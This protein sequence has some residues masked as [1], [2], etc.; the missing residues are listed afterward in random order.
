MRRHLTPEES[1]KI[2]I[3]KSQGA[4]L[5]Q[6]LFRFD[7]SRATYFGVLK[8]WNKKQKFYKETRN[9]TRKVSPEVLS[10]VQNHIT[11]IDR[12]ATREELIATKQSAHQ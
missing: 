9:K 10:Q 5:E 1:Y 3:A 11:N 2:V 4:T 8:E 12:S 6:I 7:I